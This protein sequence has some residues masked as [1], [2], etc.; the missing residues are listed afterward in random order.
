MGWRWNP[1]DYVT[2][3]LVAR[4]LPPVSESH[5]AVAV[6]GVNATSPE[7]D[8]LMANL[9]NSVIKVLT[10]VVVVLLVLVI[11]PTIAPFVTAKLPE[12]GAAVGNLLTAIW[13]AFSHVIHNLDWEV[14][15]SE[16]YDRP[17][18]GTRP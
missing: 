18:V 10:V 1:N 12:F 4:N 13:Q 9:I 7:R 6:S 8:S 3:P 17:T 16:H 15:P 14:R 11:V 5:G 2:K